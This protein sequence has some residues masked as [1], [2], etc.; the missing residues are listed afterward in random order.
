M[1]RLAQA[2]RPAMRRVVNDDHV[3][4]VRTALRTPETPSSDPGS[5]ES[6]RHAIPTDHARQVTSA[7]FIE[8]ALSRVHSIPTVLDLGCG[9]GASRQTFLRAN[10]EV[11]WVGI[12]ITDSMESEA[13]GVLDANVVLFDGL[14]LPFEDSSFEIIYSHQVFEHVQY[15]DV[16]LREVARVL[17][18]D[19]VFVGSTSQMEPF[20]SR[21]HWGYTPPGFA[22]VLSDTG[23][24][25]DEIR[26]GIDA[27]TLI[28]R[29]YGGPDV[30]AEYGK[31]FAEESPL[32]AKINKWGSD[33]GRG[34]GAV[35]DRK[36][37]FCGQFAFMASTPSSATDR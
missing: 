11:T 35:N 10:P 30:R 34:A 37:R 7:Y 28:E 5:W 25:L 33:S 24:S 18:A 23:L 17:H 13:R 15:P 12:D 22:S 29:A 4:V 9:V 36:L 6:I 1:T 32:N 16:L 26:P 20:H 21:S 31:W 19:G 2:I 14:R 3:R 27:I 8:A